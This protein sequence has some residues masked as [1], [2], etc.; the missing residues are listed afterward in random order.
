MTRLNLNITETEED[1]VTL[2]NQ[3]IGDRSKER[4][5]ALY[6]LKI[7]RVTTLKDLAKTIGRNT[8]TLSRWFRTY[9]TQGIDRLLGD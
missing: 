6:L 8:A 5:V 2:L 3:Q 4:V 1:L 9:K 7:G